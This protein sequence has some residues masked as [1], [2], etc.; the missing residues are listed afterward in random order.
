MR[1]PPGERGGGRGR[2]RG[3]RR[4]GRGRTVRMLQPTLL[5]LLHRGP[6][7]GY[8]LLEQLEEF[9]MGGLNPSVVYRALRSMEDKGWVASTWD[10][11]QTQGPPR[12]VYQITEAGDAA[13][14]VWIEDLKDSRRMLDH[15]LQMYERHMKEGEGAYH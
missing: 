2:G 6:A 1:G 4:R 15:I 10:N 8:T 14:T 11:E 3:G 5:L 9:G 12:R 13:L 7:H